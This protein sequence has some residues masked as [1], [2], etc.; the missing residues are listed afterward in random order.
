MSLNI[1]LLESSFARLEE[2]RF[3]NHF[4]TILFA[5]YP[6]L[7]P[8]FANTL[9]EE[10]SKKLFKSLA[11]VVENLQKPDMLTEAL[12]KLGTRHITYKVLPEHYSMVGKTLLKTF[13]ICLEDKWNTDLEL[14]WIDAYTAVTELMLAEAH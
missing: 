8:L 5:D 4:Y 2:D 1:E 14:A 9:M 12:Q 7:K 13:A 11:L 6:Q 10:Q 3:T